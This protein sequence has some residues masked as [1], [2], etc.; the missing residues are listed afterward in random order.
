MAGTLP[1]VVWLQDRRGSPV[2]QLF[3]ADRS[4]D[5]G[6]VASAYYAAVP[7]RA[8]RHLHH[9]GVRYHV[10]SMVRPGFHSRPIR[11]A[12]G[13]ATIAPDPLTLAVLP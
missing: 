3:C 12:A 6:L 11:D 10:R 2:L 7:I 1:P 13:R 4:R 8:T 5:G 9:D